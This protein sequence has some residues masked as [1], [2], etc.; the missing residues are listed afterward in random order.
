MIGDVQVV[1]L[2]PETVPLADIGMDVAHGVVV[3]IPADLASNSK[4]LWRAI[5]QHRVFRLQ[6]GPNPV[7]PRL[8]PH[9]PNDT[10]Q[11]QDRLVIVE[12]E[13]AELRAAL[14]FERS[15]FD[16]ILGL[17]RAGVMATPGAPAL[18]SKFAAATPDLGVVEVAT[19]TFIPSTIKSDSSESRVTVQEGASESGAVSDARS[20]L[21]KMR[22][23]E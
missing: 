16:E 20:A 5:N 10:Q 1:G 8:A 14:G 15:K 12:R 18:A 9:L 4:D 2:V 23:N 7:N 21:R 17:L 19:P 6:A 22:R 13:N 3:T 11:L